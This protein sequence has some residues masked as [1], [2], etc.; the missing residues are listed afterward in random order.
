MENEL[1]NGTAKRVTRRVKNMTDIRIQEY[2]FDMG[3]FRKSG[4]YALPPEA[5][6]NTNANSRCRRCV[7]L[8]NNDPYGVHL[9][10]MVRTWDFMNLMASKAEAVWKKEKT[11][12]DN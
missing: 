5:Y 2:T 10:Q 3:V 6:H 7:I 4:I 1:L 8:P 9:P 12:D 11:H